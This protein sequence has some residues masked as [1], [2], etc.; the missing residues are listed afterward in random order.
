MLTIFFRRRS[1]AVGVACVLIG[2]ILPMIC[3]GCA[4]ALESHRV[5]LAGAQIPVELVENWLG[6]SRSVHF[7]TQRVQFY[8]SQHGFQNL[9]AGTCDIA[10]TD[11]PLTRRERDEFGATSVTGR[12]VGFYGFALYVHPQNPVDSIFAKHIGPLFSGQV[13]DWKELGPQEGPI[14]ILGPAKSSRGGQVLVRETRVIIAPAPWEVLP[15]S[16]AIVAAVADDPSAVGL[17]SIGF[18]QGARC[19]GVRMERN[20]PPVFP[21]L[22][23]IEQDRYG[24][25]KVIYVYATEPLSPAAQAVFDYLLGPEG[26]RAIERTEVWP[27]PPERALV[28]PPE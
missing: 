6:E 4:P 2:S 14:R 18:D 27:V 26:Q 21:V 23:D 24:L 15:S 13:R 28:G 7:R 17:A 16:S 19:L 3:A 25:A 8:L 1:C 11:R 12:R 22:E 5:R 20:A 10:C 9:K